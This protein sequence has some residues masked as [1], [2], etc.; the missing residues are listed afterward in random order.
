MKIKPIVL[1]LCSNGVVA[2]MGDECCFC[3]QL[4]S[5]REVRC[6]LGYSKFKRMVFEKN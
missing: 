6:L 4:C 5:F 2:T 1:G 3:E